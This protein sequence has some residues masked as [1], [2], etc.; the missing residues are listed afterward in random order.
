VGR[1][2]RGNL[3]GLLSSLAGMPGARTVT[4]ERVRFQVGAIEDAMRFIK[5][6]QGTGALTIHFHSGKPHGEA[7]WKTAVNGEAATSPD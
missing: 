4:E 3:Q 6:L 5:Q 2:G 1:N 7:Q